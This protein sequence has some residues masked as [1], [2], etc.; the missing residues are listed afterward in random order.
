MGQGLTLSPHDVQREGCWSGAGRA[1]NQVDVLP[2][3]PRGRGVSVW[4]FG[5]E[6]GLQ[7]RPGRGRA[8][9]ELGERGSGP[10]P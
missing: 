10:A 5:R 9:Q 1:D 6:V 8:A 4:V 2:C 3:Y 7:Q